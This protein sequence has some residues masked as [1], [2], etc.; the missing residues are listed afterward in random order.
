MSITAADIIRIAGDMR[1]KKHNFM[2][3]A[4]AAAKMCIPAK[5]N[6]T[7]TRSD[8][9]RVDTDLFDSTGID[10][11]QI[12]AAGL[13]AFLTS[14]YSQW[15]TIG[16]KK[17]AH[18][19]N[20]QLQEWAAETAEVVYDSLNGSNFN[21]NMAMFY[22]DFVVLP[23][24]TIYRE[25]D[26]KDIFRFY[27][28]PFEEVLIRQ[29]SRGIVDMVY[30]CFKYDVYQAY[31]RWGQNAGAEIIE[32]WNKKKFDEKFDFIHATAPRH[33]RNVAKKDGKNMP[34][35]S[36]F[37]NET[38]K[39]KIEETGYNRMPYYVGRW[40]R[41]TGQD[42]GYTPAMIALADMLMLNTM[43]ETNLLEGQMTTSPPW[44]FPDEDFLAPFNFNPRG[45]NYRTG[46]PLEKHQNPMPLISGGQIRNGLEMEDRRRRMIEKKFFVDLFT[47]N[48]Q[49]TDKTAYEIARQ[50]ERNMLLLGSVISDVIDD[51][52]EPC[53][54]DVIQDMYEVEE[55][56]EIPVEG[57][58]F[59]DLKLDYISPLAIAMKAA[60]AQNTN[61]FLTTVGQIAQMAPEVLHKI[62]WDYQVDDLAKNY[63]VNPKVMRSQAEVQ[64]TRK[65][66]AA[67]QEKANQLMM[68]QSAGAAMKG[69]G[70]GASAINGPVQKP[71]K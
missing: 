29:N 69:L 36:C 70:E 40:G 10:S 32:M 27:S 56:P 13:Q 43:S 16:F 2:D 46:A 30:R 19:E 58:S 34:F 67:Q 42:W 61:L 35:Y 44:L 1:S 24:A 4:Q 60:K 28:I 5:A 7:V 47:V 41:L 45:I 3:Y 11:A 31:E 15:F 39:S 63:S 66:I 23:G 53:L 8:G 68:L 14:P 65:A 64:A 50:M 9:E 6:I 22:Q 62:N 26:P 21:R 54:I 59:E 25:K 37:V 38:K 51:V 33:K 52:L 20:K 17:R 12:L 48:Y 18:R 57:V 55:L 71:K 49:Q